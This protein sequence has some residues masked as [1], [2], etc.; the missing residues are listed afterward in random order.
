MVELLLFSNIHLQ[1]Y[2]YLK[3]DKIEMVKIH[4]FC[5]SLRKLMELSSF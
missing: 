3:D 5:D 1:S 4:G 2:L